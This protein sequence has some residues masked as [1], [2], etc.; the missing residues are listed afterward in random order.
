MPVTDAMASMRADIVLNSAPHFSD[1]RNL[2]RS[3]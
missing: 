3:R 2:S 1:R